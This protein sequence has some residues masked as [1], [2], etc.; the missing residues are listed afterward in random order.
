MRKKRTFS[1]P[2][3]QEFWTPN[4]LAIKFGI[5]NKVAYRYFNG[6]SKRP[7]HKVLTRIATAMGFDLAELVNP[8]RQY[9]QVTCHFRSNIQHLV[10]KSGRS[11]ATV[12]K[13][14]GLGSEAIPALLEGAKPTPNQIT[15][16]AQHF[17]LSLAD[18]LMKDLGKIGIRCLE[19]PG[20]ANDHT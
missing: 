4:E 3:C 5:A 17:N 2:L 11:A 9:L 13:R 8:A 14:C 1:T 18:L 19:S 16:I 20:P 15:R 12:S 6:G 10:H 7:C